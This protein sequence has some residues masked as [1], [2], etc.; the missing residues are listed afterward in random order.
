MTFVIIH[1]NTPELTTCLCSSFRKFHMTDTLV[2]FDNSDKRPFIN[3]SL[4]DT[5]YIDNTQ[6][7]I[8]N[9]EKEFSKYSIDSH[10]WQINKLGSAKHTFTIDWIIQNINDT[11]ICILDSDILIKK[12]IDFCDESMITAGELNLQE[13]NDRR[14]LQY[15]RPPRILPYIQFLNVSKL[16]KL[17]IR[18]FDHNKIMGFNINAR[19]YDTGCSFFETLL[20]KKQHTYINTNITLRDYMVHYKGGSWS[21]TDYKFWLLHYKSLWQ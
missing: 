13:Q 12:K 19:P 8:I 4:F 10:V 15:G 14:Y 11:A 20:K 21:K 9:F 18:F 7:Q 2:I 16:K 3:S 17:N 5:I 1:F 6:Q